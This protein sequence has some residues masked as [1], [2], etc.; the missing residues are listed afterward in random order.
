LVPLVLIS[1]SSKAPASASIEDIEEKLR[2]HYG[3]I[4][5]EGALYQKEVLDEEKTLGKF[6][7]KICQI[8][9]ASSDK[10]FDLN[11]VCTNEESHGF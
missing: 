9:S 6:G 8:S 2:T 10:T 5:T 1:Y 7:E 4:Y 3:K 11:K